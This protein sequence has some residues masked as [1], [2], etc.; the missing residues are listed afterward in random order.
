MMII[1]MDSFPNGF[2]MYNLKTGVETI[3]IIWRRQLEYELWS[4]LFTKSFPSKYYLK[5]SPLAT[6]IFG[7]T[8]KIGVSYIWP[9]T[10]EFAPFMIL[11]SQNTISILRR[12]DIFHFEQSAILLQASSFVIAL[13]LLIISL[14]TSIK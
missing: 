2:R 7:E 14:I 8:Y 9:M 13:H 6:L 11:D 4:Q 12:Q 3:K 5:L 10:L 1:V